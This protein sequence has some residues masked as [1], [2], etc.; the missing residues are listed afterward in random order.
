MKHQ[1]SSELEH[2]AKRATSISFF[3]NF[4]IRNAQKKY[5]EPSYTSQIVFP[6]SD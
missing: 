2:L 4:H 3:F 5:F 1:N 6:V